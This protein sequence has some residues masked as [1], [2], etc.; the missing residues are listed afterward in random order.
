MV[1]GEAGRQM[2]GLSFLV[3]CLFQPMQP[4]VTKLQEDL[5]DPFRSL[6]GG[7]LLMGENV[8]DVG[9]F[10]NLPDRSA[11]PGGNFFQEGE[12]FSQ[13]VLSKFQRRDQGED[14]RSILRSQGRKPPD[15]RARD[16]LPDDIALDL[17]LHAGKGQVCVQYFFVGLKGEQ[18]KKGLDDRGGRD[19]ETMNEFIEGNRRLHRVES[20]ARC[21]LMEGDGEQLDVAAFLLLENPGLDH[22]NSQF[23]VRAGFF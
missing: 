18:G 11:F 20:A 23:R 13:T 16:F 12:R 17:L 14:R 1:N 19:V 8:P 2:K 6:R 5:F 4:G 3:K 15:I 7:E 21:I 22:R 10:D 9:T